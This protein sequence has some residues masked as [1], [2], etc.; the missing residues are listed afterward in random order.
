MTKP[1]YIALTEKEAAKVQKHAKLEPEIFDHKPSNRFFKLFRTEGEAVNAA[2]QNFTSNSV[3]AATAPT[4]WFVLKL[5][6][7]P[8][9]WLELLLSNEPPKPTIIRGSGR[10][11]PELHVSGDLP[12]DG[13][14]L[15]WLQFTLAPI[16]ISSFAEKQLWKRPM[17][18]TAAC[19]G[20]G[21]T[22]V[23]VWLGTKRHIRQHPEEGPEQQA[24]CALCWHQFLDSNFPVKDEVS[25]A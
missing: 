16:G 18:L 15:E 25:V 24:F 17:L 20:C 5:K 2:L 1:A 10:K 8:E 22:S 7:T 19:D 13:V 6:F 3:R 21:A 4:N 14:A 23:P 9:Q 12:V 11:W